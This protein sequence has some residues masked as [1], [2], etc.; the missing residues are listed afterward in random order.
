MSDSVPPH[1][2]GAFI[3]RPG[4][5]GQAF[6]PRV[7]RPGFRHFKCDECGREWLYPS[8]DVESPSGEDC[9]CGAWIHPRPATTEEFDRLYK[10]K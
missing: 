3:A 9:T 7:P 8:R 6:S 4:E 5:A 2:K 10:H 1:L